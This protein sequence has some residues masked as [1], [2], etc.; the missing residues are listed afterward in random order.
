MPSRVWPGAQGEH[1][2]A[3]QPRRRPGSGRHGQHRRFQHRDPRRGHSAIPKPVEA[4][5][6]E[7]TY[8]LRQH[9]EVELGATQGRAPTRSP[10]S[11]TTGPRKTLAFLDPAEKLT[12]SIDG[13]D[14]GIQSSATCSP[15]AFARQCRTWMRPCGCQG[16][17]ITVEVKA[18][19][20]M[21]RAPCGPTTRQGGPGS[22]PG[23][24]AAARRRGHV[25]SEPLASRG[26]E[27]WSRSRDLSHRSRSRPGSGT[28]LS[29][30]VVSSA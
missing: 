15:T 20:Q 4:R 9:F 7:N 10:E 18:H 1:Q 3:A 17:R 5:S 8:G 22:W 16:A 2:D 28:V 23:S 30:D 29:E 21:P 25:T 27:R 6:N 12:E 11:S 14:T 24:A 26:S 19:S 13:L